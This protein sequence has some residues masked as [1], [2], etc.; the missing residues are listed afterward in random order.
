MQ[1]TIV[2]AAGKVRDLLRKADAIVEDPRLTSA[3]A[4]NPD[5]QP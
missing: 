2:P 5:D 1:G 3:R 4:A